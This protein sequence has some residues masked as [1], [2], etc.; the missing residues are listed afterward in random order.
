MTADDARSREIVG[1]LKA[2]AARLEERIKQLEG[3][4]SETGDD[5]GLI[6]VATAL[7]GA[8]TLQADIGT[9]S[10]CKDREGTFGEFVEAELKEQKRYLDCVRKTFAF[11]NDPDTMLNLVHSLIYDRRYVELLSAVSDGD[12]EAAFGIV[13]RI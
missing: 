1:I 13:D 4:L 3:R 5:A 11:V 8:K 2:V 10:D 7:Y 12:V 6:S 9:L